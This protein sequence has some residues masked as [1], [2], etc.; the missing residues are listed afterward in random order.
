MRLLSFPLGIGF[1]AVGL[2]MM[3][4]FDESDAILL[5]GFVSGAAWVAFAR[6]V[7]K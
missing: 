5:L 7:Y 4:G 1:F 6:W 3:D 2:W